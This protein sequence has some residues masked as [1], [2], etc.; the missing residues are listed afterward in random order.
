MNL[1]QRLYYR[2]NLEVNMEIGDLVELIGYP[3]IGVVKKVYADYEC[4]DNVLVVVTADGMQWSRRESEF[5]L[6]EDQ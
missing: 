3:Y 2:S 6:L 5:Y 4:G 1:P